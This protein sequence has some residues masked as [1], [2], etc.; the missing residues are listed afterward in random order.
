MDVV[1]LVMRW[2]LLAAA[3]VDLRGGPLSAL[4]VA[5]LVAAANVVAQLVL[6]WIPRSDSV[7]VLAAVT[8]LVNGA[9]V[10][11]ASALTTRLHIDGLLAAVTFALLV[12]VFSVALTSTSE[13]LLDRRGGETRDA[14]G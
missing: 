1:T 10:W 5:V 14:T 11:A 4:V 9:V 12:T 2:V 3:D 6:R 7:L 13:R 8:M